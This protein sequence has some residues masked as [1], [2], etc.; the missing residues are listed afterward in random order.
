MA[1]NDLVLRTDGD[2]HAVRTGGKLASQHLFD[3]A[4][5]HL[6]RDIR[7]GTAIGG[8]LH[9]VANII[10]IALDQRPARIIAI[11]WIAHPPARPWRDVELPN[12]VL[13]AQQIGL[14]LAA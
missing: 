5:D 9:D 13:P 8:I 12:L 6:A 1:L 2:R 7:L 11:F 14:T 3:I 10:G 4:V